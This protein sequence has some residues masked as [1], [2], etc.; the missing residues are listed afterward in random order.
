MANLGRIGRG[1][2]RW[3]IEKPNGGTEIADVQAAFAGSLGLTIDDIG[4]GMAARVANLAGNEVLLATE[5]ADD[6]PEN[7]RTFLKNNGWE[8]TE[9]RLLEPRPVTEPQS[10]APAAEA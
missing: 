8:I 9:A 5:L 7:F 1:T 6:L 3:K 2:S 4:T 10:S